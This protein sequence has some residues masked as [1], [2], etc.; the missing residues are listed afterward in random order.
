MK[1]TYKILGAI[2]VIFILLAF[3][4]ALKHAPQNSK[5]DKK[6]ESKTETVATTK[7]EHLKVKDIKIIQKE[8]ASGVQKTFKLTPE[9]KAKKEKPQTFEGITQ[10]D[11][12]PGDMITYTRPNETSPQI[13]IKSTERVLKSN[14]K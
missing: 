7:D 8:N 12:Q 5:D 14:D 1:S 9:K 10:L 6:S 3:L 11:I 13:K 2:I 4:N